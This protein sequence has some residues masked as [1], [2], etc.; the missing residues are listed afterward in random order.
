LA[1]KDLSGV[2]ESWASQPENTARSVLVTIFGDTVRPSTN[3]IWLSQL[4]QLT[5]VLGF[6]ER[7]V[8]TSMFRL[9]AEGWLSSE[10]V[11]RQSQYSLTPLAIQ[12]SEQADRR[13]Y[14]SPCP[15]WSGQWAAVFVDAP[16]LE[17]DLRN[18]LL[19]HLTWQGFIALSDGVVASPTVSVNDAHDICRRISPS[20]RL[21]VAA[22]EFSQLES[23]VADSFFVKALTVD[24]MTTSYEHFVERYEPLDTASSKAQPSQA[25]GLRTM[26]VHDL[27]RIRLRGPDLPAALLPSEWPGT[28]AHAVAASLY[29]KLS[30]QAQPWLAEVLSSDYPDRF[31]AR[32]A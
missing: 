11:G 3:A 12:E 25:F 29:P 8:R 23:L 18:Q 30:E 32:F 5:D 17:S 21:P 28:R 4:F 2:I 20:A 27:R 10:R 9:A 7:L 14:Q 15:D 31:P 26:L 6:S 19:Q 13:I 16:A 1:A 24:E 22:L